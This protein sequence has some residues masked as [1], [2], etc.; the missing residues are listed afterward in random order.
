MLKNMRE[1][2]HI[3]NGK[4]VK[5]REENETPAKPFSFLKHDFTPYGSVDPRVF[6]PVDE[7][8]IIEYLSELYDGLS[9]KEVER[10]RKFYDETTKRAVSGD[11]VEYHRYKEPEAEDKVGNL[12][13]KLIVS[14][15]IDS[16]TDEEK[17]FIEAIRFNKRKNYTSIAAIINDIIAVGKETGYQ[18]PFLI[19]VSDWR[20]PKAFNQDV[21]VRESDARK[22]IHDIKRNDKVF[23]APYGEY[24]P[25]FRKY[26]EYYTKCVDMGVEPHDCEI[27]NAIMKHLQ[28]DDRTQKWMW[29]NIKFVTTILTVITILCTVILHVSPPTEEMLFEKGYTKQYIYIDNSK[30]EMSTVD[31]VIEFVK[32]K[33]P[34]TLSLYSEKEL[35][36]E[37]KSEND[38]S[39]LGLDVKELKII[40]V[41]IVVRATEVSV[42]K[43]ETSGKYKAV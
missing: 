13:Y 37:I 10:R 14:E 5:R 7:E 22:N 34:L 35:K 28:N 3:S 2:V 40:K 19:V 42:E 38:L 43:D 12:I 27:F 16:L 31:N 21:M 33:Y 20:H 26:Y 4:I 8:D 9:D 11:D 23:A 6:E 32:D 36:K 39:F 30:M 1:L 29:T 24:D 25:I 41:P 18:F 17:S 15:D